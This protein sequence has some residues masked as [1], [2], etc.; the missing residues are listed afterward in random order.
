MHK[1]ENLV[2]LLVYLQVSVLFLI[3]N[4]PLRHVV[5]VQDLCRNMVR[6]L[7]F[8]TKSDLKG[9]YDLVTYTV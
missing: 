8:A 2:L 5:N 1:K 3:V 9:F 6:R 7:E 4:V